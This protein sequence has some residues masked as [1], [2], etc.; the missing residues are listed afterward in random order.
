[1]THKRYWFDWIYNFNFNDAFLEV[2]QALRED[3]LGSQQRII[4]WKTEQED[5]EYL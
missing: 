5:I 3:S 2:F 1:M 4:R